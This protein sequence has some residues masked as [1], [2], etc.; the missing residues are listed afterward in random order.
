MVTDSAIRDHNHSRGG[1]VHLSIVIRTRNEAGSLR[2]VFEALMAQR[3]SFKWEIIVV[4][5]ESEDETLELCK[6]YG[7]QVVPIGRDEFTYGRALNLG[8]SHARGEFVLILSAHSV[9]VG[10][11]FLESAVAPFEDSLIAAVRCLDAY[12]LEQMSQWYKPRDIQYQSLEEQRAAETGT[13]W[14]RLYPGATCCVIR[15]S[16]WEH[17]KYDEFLEAAEDKLWASQVLRKGYKVRCYVEA[18]FI[19][20]RIRGK[21]HYNNRIFRE[22]RALHKISGY[23]PLSWPQFLVRVARAVLLTPL[24]AIRYFIDKVVW[25]TGLVTIPWQAKFAKRGGSFSEFDKRT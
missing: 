13:Q 20:T 10:S 5:N 17:V 15:R 1:E 18:V 22:Y 11:S 14:T 3:C 21:A 16:V 2:V 8:I 12:D 23:V 9:P 24:V 19:Y 7:C 25:N 6:Q 4:D